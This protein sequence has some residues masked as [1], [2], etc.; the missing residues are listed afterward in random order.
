MPTHS[1]NSKTIGLYIKGDNMTTL[2]PESQQKRVRT[3]I[4]KYGSYELWKAELKRIG[5]VGGQRSKRGPVYK[6][7]KRVDNNK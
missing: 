3:M 6:Q 5:S 2:T 4:K 1:G 7:N